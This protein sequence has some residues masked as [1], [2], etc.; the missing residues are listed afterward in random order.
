MTTFTTRN[1]RELTGTVVL[2]KDGTEILVTLVPRTYDRY[3]KRA[4]RAKPRLYGAT[5]TL[6]ADLK[7][8]EPRYV[9]CTFDDSTDEEKAAE[10]AWLSWRR[11]A[12]R[13]CTRRLK[14]LLPTL[15]VLGIDAENA[16]FSYNAGCSTC[17]CSPGYVLDGTVTT[18]DGHR[19]DIHFTSTADLIRKSA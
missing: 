19:A 5:D 18:V 2:L 1:G 7:A 14:E 6:I 17:P 11:K 3:N 15:A 10:K 16:R 8:Q 4:F 13:T 9:A 12:L